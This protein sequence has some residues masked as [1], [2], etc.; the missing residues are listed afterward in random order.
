MNRRDAGQVLLLGL[1]TAGVAPF[2]HAQQA[3]RVYRIG[4]LSA[5]T[6]ES[7]E[8]ALAAFLLALRN[9]GWIEGKNLLIE[10]RWAEGNVER[11][12]ALAAEMVRLKV[13]LIVAP[14][15]SAAAAAKKASSTIP[16][17]ML[18]PSDPVAAGL[19]DS[20]PKPGGNVTG[21]TFTPGPAIYG[22]QLQLLRESVPHASR[23][24]LLWNPAD[25]ATPVQLT[26]VESAARALGIRLQRAEARGAG[27]IRCRVCGDGAGARR[28]PRRRQQ[29]DV[30]GATRPGS[31]NSR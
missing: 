30:P 1:L 5:P 24:A 23:V 28:S 2:A 15:T 19:V 27:G 18:F 21:T 9:L 7:V 14:A 13:D 31:A 6:R 3:G 10:Y 25:A 20:L 4:Y 11:L 26:E 29:H 16:I 8:K 17:V 12:P 22:K